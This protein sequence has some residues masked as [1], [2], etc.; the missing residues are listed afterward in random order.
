MRA[1]LR[2]LAPAQGSSAIL[3]DLLRR[4]KLSPFKG[5]TMLIYYVDHCAETPGP[6]SKVLHYGIQAVGIWQ[7]AMTETLMKVS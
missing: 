6:C 1:A 7:L 2:T 5:I 4:L 3:I